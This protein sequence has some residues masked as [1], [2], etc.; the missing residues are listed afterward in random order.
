VLTYGTFA[1]AINL[2]RRYK[3]E[4]TRTRRGKRRDFTA[5]LTSSN[6]FK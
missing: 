5:S 2:L 6:I 1:I 3:K 4:K